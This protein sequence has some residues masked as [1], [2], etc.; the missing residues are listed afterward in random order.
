MSL[1][2]T[3]ASIVHPACAADARQTVIVVVGAEGSEEFR[4]PFRQWAT[5]W[6]EASKAGGADVHTVGLDAESGVTDRQRLQQLLTEHGKSSAEPCWLVLIGHGT[7][8]GR[9]ARFALRGPDLSSSELAAIVKEVSRPLAILDCTSCSAPFLTDLS[10]PGRVVI[11][12]TRSGHEYNLSRLGDHLSSAI[13]DPA[14]DLDKDGQTSLLEAFLL[15]SSRVNEFYASESRL[16]TEHA[17][18]DDNGDK[19]GTPPD[20]FKGTRATKTAKD[21]AAPDG[22]L[23]NTL[24]LVRSAT[25]SQL[26]SDQR[27]RRNELE[28]RLAELRAKKAS[29]AEEDYLD[30]LEPLLLE[31]G[32]LAQ[33]HENS[34][35]TPPAAKP[36]S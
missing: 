16:A 15:A 32:E 28:T 13:R 35:S 7:F 8:D 34:P 5:R 22:R 31:L 19:Q 21:G 30:A 36:G 17:L 20:W 9:V 10:A 6:E 14:G 1:F 11:T 25:E 26:N 12:A 23:A 4:E 33:L 24:V 27:R 29:L 18:L 2:L 3:F